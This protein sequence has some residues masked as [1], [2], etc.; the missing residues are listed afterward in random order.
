[1]GLFTSENG[2]AVWSTANEGP[3]NIR[4]RELFWLDDTTLGVA[5]YGR[6]M[7]RT[8]IASAGPGNYQ[9]LWWAGAQEN[10]WGMSITQRGATL[11]T[12]IFI[13]DASGK[14]M[15]VVMPGGTWNA[16]FSAYSG[17]LYVP[18]GSFYGSYDAARFAP[19]SPVGTATIA[20]AGPGSA[21]LD[22]TVN[23][24]SGRKTIV[25]QSFGAPDTTPV[26][27][28]ADLWWGGES[29]N[30]WGVSISQQY[31]SLFAVWYTYDAAGR[32]TWFVVPGGTWTAANSWSGTAY[33]TTGSPW[34]GASYNASLFAPVPAGAI[35][36]SFGADASGGTMAY[37][38]DGVTGTK[39]IVRQPL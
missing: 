13:Y 24:V 18:S 35:T 31:R 36:F 29:Q 5:T 26:G 34:L 9:D 39:D 23:G 21:T 10:G 32:T 19:G 37:N 16:G 8:T 11:F 12:A 27:S 33:R 7:F 1:V 38:V 6:G 4:V 3:A 14:P 17:N 30:G 25:R 28:F 2:G 15:W 20:F 22:Y